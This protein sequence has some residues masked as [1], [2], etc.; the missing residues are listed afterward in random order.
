MPNSWQ[1]NAIFAT[2]CQLAVRQGVY[3]QELLYFTRMTSG[4]KEQSNFLQ[5]TFEFSNFAGALAF[6]NEV[7]AIAEQFQHHPDISMHDYKK[8][9]ISSTT[10]DT[11]N[12][13]TDKDKELARAIDE[14]VASR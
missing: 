10:H 13:V 8:V 2:C 9:T 4:W 3:M 11:G 7:G 12:M 5:K 6:V 14:V 1:Y